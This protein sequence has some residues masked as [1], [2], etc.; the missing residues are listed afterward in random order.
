MSEA[1]DQHVDDDESS[2]AHC[3][4]FHE[5]VAELLFG[6]KILI[7]Q[8]KVMKVNDFISFWY[9]FLVLTCHSISVPCRARGL[10]TAFGPQQP[11]DERERG[12][13]AATPRLSLRC[14]V[15]AL[16]R[17]AILFI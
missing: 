8:S 17:S 15:A 14:G 16:L 12:A 10:N 4:L 2:M 13:P 9:R 6:L 1:P 5:V 7:F 3:G 11:A